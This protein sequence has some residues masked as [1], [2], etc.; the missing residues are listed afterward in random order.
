[1]SANGC[2]KRDVAV[3]GV[4]AMRARVPRPAARNVQSRRRATVPLRRARARSAAPTSSTARARELRGRQPAPEAVHGAV[5]AARVDGH[6]G[7]AQR[8]GV[9]LALVAQRV[10][11]RR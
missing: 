5:E 7:L 3:V 10:E 6:A 1:M 11:A 4:A 8:L 2:Q 9:G